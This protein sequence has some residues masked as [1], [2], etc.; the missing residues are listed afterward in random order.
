MSVYLE[1]QF[2]RRDS[3]PPH[4][5]WPH[6]DACGAPQRALSQRDFCDLCELTSCLACNDRTDGYQFC[7]V[8][9]Q[10]DYVLAKGGAA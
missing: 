1:P 6:C 8:Q 7:D 9:C 5:F 2:S 10:T 4:L 3:D